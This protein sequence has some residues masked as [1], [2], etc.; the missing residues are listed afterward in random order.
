MTKADL[1]A[2]EIVNCAHTRHADHVAYEQW[3]SAI[4]Q[5]HCYPQWVDG[6]PKEEGLFIVE[7]KWGRGLNLKL[8]TSR[9]FE[10]QTTYLHGQFISLEDITRH[11]KIHLPKSY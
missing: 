7:L 8:F 4:I 10:E 11:F 9:D 1:A 6:Q 5:K 3:I 2:K